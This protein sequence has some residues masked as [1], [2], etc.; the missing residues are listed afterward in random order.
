MGTVVG[1]PSSGIVLVPTP[2]PDTDAFRT[3][4]VGR[5]LGGGPEGGLNDCAWMSDG[6]GPG[7]GLNDWAATCDGGGPGGGLN[8]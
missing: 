7:G 5:P 2:D 3:G 4:A 6:G 1:R 8:V